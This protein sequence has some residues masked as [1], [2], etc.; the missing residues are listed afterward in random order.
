MPRCLCSAL[1]RPFSSWQEAI[2]EESAGLLA[3]GAVPTCT[4]REG[5]GFFGNS[6]IS[7]AVFLPQCQAVFDIMLKGTSLQAHDQHFCDLGQDSAPE[8][9]TTQMRKAF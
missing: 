6:Q 2:R 1:E 4:D 9:A 3:K 8:T 7:S 5:E